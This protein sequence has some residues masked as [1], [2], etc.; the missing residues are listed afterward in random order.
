[1]T[2]RQDL[3]LKR[4]K[5]LNFGALTAD[6]NGVIIYKDEAVGP[7]LEVHCV[8]HSCALY[9]V[10]VHPPV[11]SHTVPEHKRRGALVFESSRELFC[12][13]C[14]CYMAAN[15][16]HAHCSII[17]A[18]H[19]CKIKIILRIRMYHGSQIRIFPSRIPDLGSKR[20]RIP[21]PER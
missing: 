4:E 18:N 10:H 17:I 12:Q 19:S 8:L 9:A 16:Q 5:N 21:D 15:F 6:S 7:A 13:C 20:Y 2:L 14:G 1:M 11:D 3:E